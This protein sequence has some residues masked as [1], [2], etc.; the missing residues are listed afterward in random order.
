MSTEKWPYR[1]AKVAYLRQRLPS[2][3]VNKG[4][5]DID[6]HGKMVDSFGCEMHARVLHEERD[7]QA[8]FVTRPFGKEASAMVTADQTKGNN[9]NQQQPTT[10]SSKKPK[11]TK[12][13][14]YK[15]K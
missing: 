8:G 11:H 3:K 14:K 5:Q 15:I 13:I 10:D 1:A 9:N 2:R 12:N 4:G 6:E 7:F